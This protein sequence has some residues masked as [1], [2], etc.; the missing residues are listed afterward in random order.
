MRSARVLVVSELLPDVVVDHLIV[1]GHFFHELEEFLP[2]FVRFHLEELGVLG[3][4]LDHFETLD[5]ALIFIQLHDQP[6][7]VLVQ[8]RASLVVLVDHLRSGGILER[9]RDIDLDTG[10]AAATADRFLPVPQPSGTTARLLQLTSSRLRLIQG[11]EHRGRLLPFRLFD[12]RVVLGRLG[13][14]LCPRFNIEEG[15][16]ASKGCHVDGVETLKALLAPLLLFVSIPRG[17]GAEEASHE[18]RLLASLRFQRHC[19]WSV[20]LVV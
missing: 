4:D 15:V 17:P 19:R 7:L 11:R 2:Q 18:A 12:A 16:L 8:E 9:L 6:L 10:Y 1:A 5:E 14:F 3:N 20:G 13:V